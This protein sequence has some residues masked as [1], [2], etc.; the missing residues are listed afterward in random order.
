MPHFVIECSDGVLHSTTPP[1]IIKEVYN[2]ALSS[3]LF[4]KEGPNGVKV[5]LKSYEHYTTVNTNEDFIHVFA[6]IMEGRTIEQKNMLSNMI[7]SR[8]KELRPQ[9]PI[10]S[11]NVYEF[12]KASYCNKAMS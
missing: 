12:E 9:V 4:A 7:V 6:N 3:D 5:R 10:I 11:M 2:A 8:L 1:T